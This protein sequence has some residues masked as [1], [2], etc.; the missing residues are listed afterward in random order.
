MLASAS[1]TLVQTFEPLLS[2]AT[3]LPGFSVHSSIMPAS[4]QRAR[5]R[6]DIWPPTQMLLRPSLEHDDA[7]IDD[8]DLAM[9]EDPIAYFLTPAPSSDDEDLDMMDFDAGIEDS[10]H[11]APIVRSVSPS[12]LEGLRLPPPRPPTPPK[13]P[14]TPDLDSDRAC[15]PDDD[16]E[17]Y[18]HF[19]GGHSRTLPTLFGPRETGSSR[20]K[21]SEGMLSPGSYLEASRANRGRAVARPGPW[22]HGAAGGLSGRTHARSS[23][24]PPRAWRE[25]SP[26]VWS[27]EEEG[28]DAASIDAGES[29]LVNGQGSKHSGSKNID[30]AAAKPKKRVRFVL[31]PKRGGRLSEDAYFGAEVIAFTGCISGGGEAV[32]V[33]RML[34]FRQLVALS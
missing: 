25:P 34:H 33:L 5:A 20:H 6:W 26:D 8:L 31:P 30:V 11:P 32:W 3:W 24:R 12:S 1:S 15:T 13:S 7:D 19:S 4:E 28:E 27:I 18:I 21:G 17:D 10:K 9:D 22:A 14:S 23:R 16:D 2:P 29:A